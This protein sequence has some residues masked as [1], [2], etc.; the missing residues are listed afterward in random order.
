MYYSC[1]FRPP[2]ALAVI[3]VWGFINVFVIYL[4][5]WKLL[6][7]NVLMCL[8]KLFFYFPL[9]T[10]AFWPVNLLQVTLFIINDNSKNQVKTTEWK[11]MVWPFTIT[12]KQSSGKLGQLQG[13][14]HALFLQGENL[15]L[16]FISKLP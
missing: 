13:A 10:L 2:D 15:L 12:F 16:F 7:D 4:L 3:G 8:S 6:G 14:S 9:Y 11:H 5:K 1:L